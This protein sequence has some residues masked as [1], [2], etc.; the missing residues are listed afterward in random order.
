M[1]RGTHFLEA[2]FDGSVDKQDSK[3]SHDAF[4]AVEVLIAYLDSPGFRWMLFFF[5]SLLSC[6]FIFSR[7]PCMLSGD[8]INLERDVGLHPRPISCK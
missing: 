1:G 8:I 4:V 2:V 7:R 6:L 3:N 5:L